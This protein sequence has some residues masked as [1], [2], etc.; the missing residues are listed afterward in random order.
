[1]PSLTDTAE[2]L[3]EQMARISKHSLTG[4][5]RSDAIDHCLSGIAR[6]SSE[7]QDASSYVPAYDQR[8]YGEAIKALN[9]KLQEVRQ[10]HAPKPKFS[11]KSKSGAFFTA[12]KNASA[13][14]VNDA[15]ELAHQEQLKAPPHLHD[16][17]CGSSMPTTPVGS[18]TPAHESAVEGAAAMDRFP[19]ATGI[20]SQSKSLDVSDHKG[21]HV[22]L[23]TTASHAISSGTVS[24]IRQCVVDLSQATADEPLAALYLKNIASSLIICGHV[25][26]AI[27]MHNITDSVILVATRQ[28]RMHDSTNCNVYLLATG[29]PIIENC[30]AI[31]FAPLPQAYML[32][33]DKQVENKWSDVDDFKWLRGEQSPHW[34]VLAPEKRVAEQVWRVI[35]LDGPKTSVQNA[36]DAVN[37]PIQE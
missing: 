18:S 37:M 12:G 5:E 20:D 28:F 2:D 16:V 9:H 29:R 22:V 1:M 34:S 31:C 24:N 25:S 36:L 33:N 10:S 23:P 15:A 6:L 30:D 13:I 27:M 17:S 26:G 3:Q 14:S 4:G 8:T 11:F 19:P 21:M 7:V 32:E 35:A